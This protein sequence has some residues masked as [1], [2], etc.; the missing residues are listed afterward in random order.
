MPAS[1]T[2]PS[3]GLKNLICVALGLLSVI[4]QATIVPS[5]GTPIGLRMVADLDLEARRVA[6][7]QAGAGRAAGDRGGV[8]HSEHAHFGQLRR[9]H[10]RQREGEQR[11]SRI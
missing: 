1:E 8:G 4:V 11:R 3:L 6:D 5:R 2:P 10:G 7:R 9:R